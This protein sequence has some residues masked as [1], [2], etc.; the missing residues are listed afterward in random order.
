MSKDLTNSVLDRQN[1]L[2]NYFGNEM[3]FVTKTTKTKI[4][5]LKIFNAI[6]K[7]SP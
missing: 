4:L 3:D 2:N 6:S 1:I 7:G 5:K